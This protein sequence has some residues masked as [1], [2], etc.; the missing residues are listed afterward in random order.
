MIGYSIFQS[1]Y[2]L[3]AE[4]CNLW[5]NWD[6]IDDG[7][8]NV[9]EILQW[10]SSNQDRLAPFHGPGHWNDPDMVRI[11]VSKKLKWIFLIAESFPSHL[12]AKLEPHVIMRDVNVLLLT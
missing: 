12:K 1:N 10:F 7:W 4:N 5:R 8:A 6:D 11:D 2:S 3:A 9:T